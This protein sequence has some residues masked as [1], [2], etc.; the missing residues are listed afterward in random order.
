MIRFIV[1]LVAA[2]AVLS[3]AGRYQPRSKAPADAGGGS[4]TGSWR[5]AYL[6]DI[7]CR[8]SFGGGLVG[9]SVRNDFQLGAVIDTLNDLSVPVMV[10]GGDWAED[11]FIANN[12]ANIDSFE[13]KLG[14][15]RG[16]ILPCL[17]NHEASAQ[18]T[19]LGLDPYYTSKKRFASKFQGKNWYKYDYR[20]VRFIALQNSANYNIGAGSDYRVNNPTTY[21]APA[22]GVTGY[23]YD[24]ITVTSSPQRV[25]LAL[26]TKRTSVGSRWVI[27][28]FHR[29]IYG[30][31]SNNSARLNFGRAAR[32]TGYIKAIEDSLPTSRRGLA[33]F[34]DQH[35]NYI[36]TKSVADSAL[37][38]ATG[39]GLHHLIV[40]SGSGSRIG[41][42][43]S[44][45][46]NFYDSYL[47]SNG[48]ETANLTGSTTGAIADTFTVVGDPCRAYQYTWSLC[49]VDADLMTIETFAVWTTC[50][51]NQNAYTGAGS[52]L[53]IDRVFIKRDVH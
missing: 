5:F 25:D 4:T 36:L 1:F 29:G 18:D 39:K 11:V 9:N 13:A 34:G 2:L 44:V 26:W 32:G 10:I 8:W 22:G 50:Q 35:L 7:H 45:P 33:L 31:N 30:A 12:A 15:F 37:S 16:I 20:N 46:A 43:T 14:R 49:T 53:L 24:G 42:S 17:G 51:S 41:D 28:I 23:D 47:F 27:P 48:A 3:T 40:G 38:S 19:I 21:A 52:H 6:T